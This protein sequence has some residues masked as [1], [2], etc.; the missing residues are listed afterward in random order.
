MAL[1][2]FA[3]Y[4]LK[5]V[6]VLSQAFHSE[7]LFVLS[8]LSPAIPSPLARW[9]HWDSQTHFRPTRPH[10][11]LPPVCLPEF[12]IGSPQP[13]SHLSVISLLALGRFQEETPFYRAQCHLTSKPPRQHLRTTAPIAFQSLSVIRRVSSESFR[14]TFQNWK[15]LPSTNQMQPHMQCKDF[16][17]LLIQA[18]PIA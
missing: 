18:L 12:A 9:S 13:P 4:S 2:P 8:Y 16:S 1:T 3:A 15:V 5:K 11:S 7:F 14:L 6:Q 17:L 10:G